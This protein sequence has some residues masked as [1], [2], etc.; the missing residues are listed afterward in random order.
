M[1]NK[2]FFLALNRIPSI[3]P[4]TIMK[5]LRQWPNLQALFSSSETQLKEAGLSEQMCLGI[6]QVNW[7]KVEEDLAWEENANHHLLTWDH[8]FYPPLLREI[9]A[10]PPV[11]Y[12]KGC[13]N[14]CEK[15]AIAMVGTRNPSITGSETAYQFAK[16]LGQHEISIVSG[17][18]LGIDAKVHEGCLSANGQTIA[19]MGTGINRIYPARHA[20]LAEKISEKGLLISEFPLDTPP[21]S[22]HFPRRNRIIS[23]LSLFTVVI[24]ATIRSGSLITARFA[25]EQNRDV[26]AVPGSIYNPQASGCHYLVQQG[27]KLV[28]SAKDI[29]QELDFEWVVNGNANGQPPLAAINENLIKFIGFEVTTADTVC[30]RSNLPIEKVTCA[31]TELEIQ[32]LIKAVPGGYMRCSK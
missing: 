20:H 22:G 15:K 16:I 24:E 18:A 25:L 21:A 32:G 27:A 2:P 17:L 19:V 29:L 4:R 12:A 13:L 23:G 10:S 26:L 3:G 5:C 6:R 31:L 30:K 7:K 9:Y 14:A 28:S 1:D 11:L 8:S